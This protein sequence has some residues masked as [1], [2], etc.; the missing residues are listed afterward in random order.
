MA[1]FIKPNDECQRDNLE[2]WLRKVYKEHHVHLAQ[3]IKERNIKTIRSEIQLEQYSKAVA[4]FCEI[5]WKHDWIVDVTVFCSSMYIMSGLSI[6]VDRS[7]M[8]TENWMRLS[9]IA[10]TE[11]HCWLLMLAVAKIIHT[12]VQQHVV[13]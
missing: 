9:L 13:S 2:K 11:W 12:T 1:N 7:S 4:E 6:L 10:P 5:V 8:S 3:F